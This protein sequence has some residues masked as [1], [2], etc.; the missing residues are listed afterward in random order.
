MAIRRQSIGTSR[1]RSF[2][3]RIVRIVRVVRIVRFVP[4]GIPGAS[5]P[6]TRP[7]R[8]RRGDTRRCPAPG[9]RRDART[10]TRCTCGG[11]SIASHGGAG[12]RRRRSI[13]RNASRRRPLGRRR[14][15]HC[16]ACRITDSRSGVR[17]RIDRASWDGAELRTGAV[18]R[19]RRTDPPIPDPRIPRRR[20]D[21]VDDRPVDVVDAQ[22]VRACPCQDPP[23]AA[24][25]QRRRIPL[26][27]VAGIAA[28][29]RPRGTRALRARR[30]RSPRRDRGRAA[31]RSARRTTAAAA[32][33][34]HPSSAAANRSAPIACPASC[35]Q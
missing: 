10:A 26:E 23:A 19:H 21:V 29:S 16:G 3:R 5:P 30:R 24:A 9:P 14:P 31:P 2:G 25:H 12:G 13:D 8:R 32:P 15:A 22:T 28:R 11:Q 17:L 27:P 6:S 35:W 4:R 18:A 7:A 33:A 20:G 1:N 34:R